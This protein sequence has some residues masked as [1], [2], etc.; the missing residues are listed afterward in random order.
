MKFAYYFCDYRSSEKKHGR[1]VFS[2]LVADLSLTCPE[3]LEAAIRRWRARKT[4]NKAYQREPL[5]QEQLTSLLEESCKGEDPVILVI[6]A[7]DECDNELEVI[8]NLVRLYDGVQAPIKILVTSRRKS[9]DFHT[10][11]RHE[12][13][14][15]SVF[16]DNNNPGV[17]HDIECFVRHNIETRIEKSKTSRTQR[18]WLG[19][20]ETRKATVIRTI[21]Q[22]AS[23]M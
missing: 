18:R 12:H 7:L 16:L 21:T 2:N 15:E 22:K 1:S 23:G 9:T 4:A 17:C 20:S 19:G 13:G 3:V 5:S 6:D 8:K 10:T 14:V 11:F